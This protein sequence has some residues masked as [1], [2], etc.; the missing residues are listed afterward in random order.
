MA[1]EKILRGIIGISG[2]VGVV[3]VAQDGEV[4]ASWAAPDGLEMDLV[5]AHY[6]LAL[7][8]IKEAGARVNPDAEV[9]SVI[10]STA[11]FKQLIT[12]IKDG[13]SLVIIMKKHALSARVLFESG[14]I[15]R[16]IE[17]EMR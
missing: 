2:V 3:M 8:R 14:K 7:A 5:G 1:F 16:E 10:A 11:R 13:Y 12:V 17:E 15:V 6:A 4:V 9:R